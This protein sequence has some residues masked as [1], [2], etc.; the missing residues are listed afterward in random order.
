MARSVRLD[1]LGNLF[2]PRSDVCHWGYAYTMLQ[3]IH[4]HGVCN[5]VYATLYWKQPLKSFDKSR[6]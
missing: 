6:T 4:M 1:I 5:D 3:S 2:E